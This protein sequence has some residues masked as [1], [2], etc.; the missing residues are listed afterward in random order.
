MV[1]WCLCVCVQL[2]SHV[3]PFMAP[4]T[5]ALQASVPIEFSRKECC[6]RLPFPTPGDLPSYSRGSSHMLVCHLT[7]SWQVNWATELNWIN[8]DPPH[9]KHE[10]IFDNVRNM[11]QLKELCNQVPIYNGLILFYPPFCCSTPPRLCLLSLILKISS[12]IDSPGGP[13]VKNL[14]ANAR[15]TGLILGLGRLHMHVMGKLSLCTT[16]TEACLSA[17]TSGAKN[18]KQYSHK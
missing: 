6:S 10:I 5:V 8:K 17:E 7:L 12:V 3:W 18:K 16:A 9:S 4:W 14:P 11:T 1:T 2:L 13:V 15:N